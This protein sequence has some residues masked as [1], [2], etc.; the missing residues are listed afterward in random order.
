[1]NK[2]WSADQRKGGEI[3]IHRHGLLAKKG[4]CRFSLA[5]G[6]TL[7][8]LSQYKLGGQELGYSCDRIGIREF[9]SLTKTKHVIA[10]RRDTQL[11]PWLIG[12]IRARLS[13]LP[14]ASA[15]FSLSLLHDCVS[16]LPTASKQYQNAYRSTSS[17]S[18][19]PAAA[20]RP[21]AIPSHADD[22]CLS[23]KPLHQLHALRARHFAR[24]QG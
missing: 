10:T 22:V 23:A 16:V 4:G 15:R 14:F 24:S 1:V 20:G 8:N 13:F 19:R 18:S 5:N 6:D 17:L 21:A 3:T 12:K 11:G 9:G 7:T 2:I